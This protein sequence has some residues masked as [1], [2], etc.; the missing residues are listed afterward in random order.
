M[1][2]EVPI[3]RRNLLADKLKF[4]L[5]LAGVSL[6]VAL[7]LVIQSVYQGVR[8]DN[9]SFIRSLPGDGWVAQRGISGL[10]LSNSFLTDSDAEA[11]ARVPG[12]TAVHRLYG[13]FTSFEVDAGEV[14][15]YVWALA[16]GGDVAAED[17][18]FLLEPGTIAIDRALARS[19]GLSRGD[20][21]KHSG[22]EF[23]VGEIG[24]IGNLILAQFTFIHYEDYFHLFGGRSA[25]SFFLISLGPEATDGTLEE[26]GRRIPGTSVYSTD[27]FIGVSEQSVRDFLAVVQ[28]VTG[29]SFVLG[30]SLL[31]LTIY[32]ATI[33][34][35]REYG[36]MKVLGASPFR[37]YRIVLS[38]SALIA[39][40]GFAV[41][42]GLAFLINR[43]A[44]NVVPE[45]ST[46]IRWEDVALVL[47]ATAVMTFLASFL[48]ISHIARVE[49]GSVF[50]A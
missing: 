31:S 32:S 21:L 3:A 50:R 28:V 49:P 39:G 18:P 40:L 19:A 2:A 11:V 1:G 46:Y 29:I 41:G 7:I 4:L 48:P 20:L 12:V 23:A 17:G 8:R 34:R 47:L 27:Q 42:I 38:Q 36:I 13:R 15:V 5:A 14:Q 25:A 44:Q 33:E 22:T 26:V 6:A 35:A 24:Q 9:A 16:P 30:L 43:A 10:T 45:F 37:L